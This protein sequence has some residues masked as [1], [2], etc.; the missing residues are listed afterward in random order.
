MRYSGVSVAAALVL[1]TFCS[2]ANDRQARESGT[3]RDNAGGFSSNDTLATSARGDSAAIPEAAPAP[4]GI[5]SQ[6]NVANTSEITLGR[7][8][9]QKAASPAV[10]QIA[11]RLISDHTK[12]RQQ[13]KAL[14][15]KLNLSL[16]PARGGNASAI[17]EADSSAF[18]AELEGK[19]GPEFDRAYVQHEIGDHQSNIDKIQNQLLPAAQDQQVKAYLQQTL[20]EMQGHLAELKNVDGKIRG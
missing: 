10:K 16:T 15:Q 12:N 2:P 3:G 19:S 1:L 5:L 6:L 4:T 20:T 13:L 7:L 18:P 9:S 14:A 8:A 11:R 17:S